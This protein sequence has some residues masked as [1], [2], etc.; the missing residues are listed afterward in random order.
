MSKINFSARLRKNIRYLGFFCEVVPHWHPRTQA[1]WLI[2]LSLSFKFTGGYLWVQPL[3]RGPWSH[4]ASPLV[5]CSTSILTKP[6]VCILTFSNTGHF[7]WKCIPKFPFLHRIYCMKESFLSSSC[8]AYTANWYERLGAL[9]PFCNVSCPVYLRTEHIYW[10]VAADAVGWSYTFHRL[11]SV[12]FLFLIQF[13]NL[14]LNLLKD[15]ERK[16]SGWTG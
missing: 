7:E 16:G 15:N 3:Y 6:E 14:D 8:A 13:L 1:H 5:F 9:P 4:S 2:A 10:L 11:H 12:C